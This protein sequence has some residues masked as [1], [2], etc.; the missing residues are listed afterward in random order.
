VQE[1][2][3]EQQRGQSTLRVAAIASSWLAW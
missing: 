2:C 3:G 1:R